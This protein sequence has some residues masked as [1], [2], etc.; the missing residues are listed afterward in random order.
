MKVFLL[1][2]VSFETNGYDGKTLEGV[3]ST[4]DKVCEYL[5]IDNIDEMS[6]YY[7]VEEWEVDEPNK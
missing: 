6:K 2:D 7:E 4:I 1:F 5:S 3:F